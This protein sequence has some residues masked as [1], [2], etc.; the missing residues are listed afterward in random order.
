[1]R[2]QE[3]AILHFFD[4]WH[5]SK[6][7]KKSLN[8][9]SKGQE[10]GLLAV[11]AQPA[12]N[13]MYW[14]AAASQGNGILLVD[15]WMSMTRHVVN[16][17]KDH[18]GLYTRCFHDPIEE[19]EW[20]VPGTPAHARFLDIVTR[21]QLVNDLRQLSP[22]TQTYALES[23][24]SVLNGFATKA[25]A[26]STGGMIARTRVAALH[27]NENSDRVQATTQAGDLQWMYKSPKARKGH[28]TANPRLTKTTYG[29]IR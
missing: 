18:P 13:H 28:H 26:F 24:H 5:V 3:P 11:W 6:S 25:F 4:V 27:Y 2:E 20:L 19:G 21:K 7:V 29:N 12:V 14:C 17:H 23:F 22:D 15:A 9:A 8:A 1:M 16:I 10:C